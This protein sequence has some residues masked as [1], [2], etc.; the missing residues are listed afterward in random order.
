MVTLSAC[1]AVGIRACTAFMYRSIASRRTIL[2]TFVFLPGLGSGSQRTSL[3][4]NNIQRL[5]SWSSSAGSCGGSRTSSHA[6]RSSSRA[7]VRGTAH[8]RIGAHGSPSSL[9]ARNS[10][11]PIFNTVATNVTIKT[12]LSCPS[13]ESWGG[14]RA[15]D[16]RDGNRPARRAPRHRYFPK[17]VATPAACYGSRNQKDD[18]PWFKR[19]TTRAVSRRMS[20]T[21]S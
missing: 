4:P 15:L 12:S 16:D 21:M 10:R 13:L 8:A 18:R 19:T 1:R 7:P 2:R 14:A 6:E 20:S 17:F 11:A 5:R 3:A 9:T